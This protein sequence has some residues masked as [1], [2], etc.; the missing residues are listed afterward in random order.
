MIFRVIFR[1]LLPVLAAGCAIFA[2]GAAAA[3]DTDAGAA[4]DGQTA[5]AA[6][7]TAARVR[8]LHD[9]LRITAE[10]EEL[11]GKVGEAIRDSARNL[12]PLLKERLRASAGGSAP[13]LLHAYEALGE[14][15]LD[16]QRKIMSVFEPLYASLSDIQKKIADAII[17]EGAQSAMI[18]PPVPAPFMPAPALPQVVYPPAVYPP[19][20]Y[21]LQS[22]PRVAVT[23][24]YPVV[25]RRFH[26]HIRP[27]S[28]SGRFHRR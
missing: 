21:P 8:H 7:P 24:P 28:R 27:H 15:Q 4:P 22:E 19:T 17:R 6:D 5:A 9:R 20:V 1:A 25:I 13:E 14:A 2:A 18:L 23:A 26:V 12:A 16:S 10:Q 3:Q 11:W